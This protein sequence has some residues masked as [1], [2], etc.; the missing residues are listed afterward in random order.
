MFGHPY[1]DSA[2]RLEF[3]SLCRAVIHHPTDRT[4]IEELANMLISEGN[5]EQADV[6]RRGVLKKPESSEPLIVYTIADYECN[7][8]IDFWAI[9]R[10]SRIT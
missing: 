6:L 5:D 3:E 2:K 8:S 10:P 9:E 1:I 4:A 7:L